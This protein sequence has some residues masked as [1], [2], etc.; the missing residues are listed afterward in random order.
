MTRL[1]LANRMQEIVL[2]PEG[3]GGAR[4]NNIVQF[5][6]AGVLKACDSCHI[7]HLTWLLLAVGCCWLLLGDNTVF[8]PIQ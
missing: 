3:D 5:G 6:G 8:E 2:S 1:T 4:V 7:V